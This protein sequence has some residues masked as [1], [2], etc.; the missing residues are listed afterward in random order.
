VT[1]QRAVGGIYRDPN[2]R[3]PL[4]AVDATD[5]T[6]AVALGNA[7]S[8]FTTSNG[9]SWDDWSNGSPTIPF[10]FARTDAQHV[11]SA[12]SNSEVLRTTNGGRRWQRSI[13]QAQIE[14]D[15]CSNA[16]DVAFLNNQVGWAVINGLYTTS[17]WVWKTTDGGVTWE[18]M[19]VTNTGGLT[20]IAIVD[21]NTLVAVNGKFDEIYRS[22][23]GGHHFS[24]VPHTHVGGWFGNV[25]FVPGTGV[26]WAVGEHKILKSVDGGATWTIQR[27]NN[28][29]Y[30]IDVSFSDVNNGWAVGGVELHTTNGGQ[31]WTKV[32]TGV[33][34]S[35]SVWTVSPSVAWIGGYESIGR[36]TNG[37]A[38]WT[39]ESPSQTDW[40]AVTALNG[41]TGW[42]GGQDQN[43]DD[44]PGSIWKRSAPDV[45]TRST[46]P[47]APHRTL[48]PPSSAP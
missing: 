3:Y 23:D 7:S 5:A 31:T 2:N 37:G 28:E 38:T 45:G 33:Q 43:A 22:T 6:D 46:P 16:A 42:V 8:V 41:G 1:W 27:A 32:N 29:E 47:R 25:R 4:E 15:R 17:S 34:G 11:W 44:V 39:V 26:G 13:I 40:Y 30:L 10:R 21:A 48:K 18:S 14:C 36:T 12:N 35:V 20:G 24:L 19:D 9:S